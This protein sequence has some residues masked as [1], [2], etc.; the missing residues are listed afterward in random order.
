MYSETFLPFLQYRGKIIWYKMEE[1][2]KQA[3]RE[4]YR[5]LKKVR[6]QLA[7]VRKELA[8]N[9]QQIKRLLKLV[10]R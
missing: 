1:I 6:E 2:R 8:E 3:R 4:I 7:A 9:K 10:R 5:Q